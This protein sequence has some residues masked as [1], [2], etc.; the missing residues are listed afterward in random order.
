MKHGMKQPVFFLNILLITV[1]IISINGCS[2]FTTSGPQRFPQLQSQRLPV[3]TMDITIPHLSNCTHED[4]RRLRLN[5]DEPVTML[6]HGCNG[7]AGKFLA[8]ANVFAF[9]GQQT[10]CFNYNDRDSMMDS[11]ALLIDALKTLISRMNN[12]S[13]TVI[14]HSQGGLV[15]RKAFIQERNEKPDWHMAARFRL[16][17]IS[18]PFAGISASEHCGSKT[19]TNVSLGTI[20]PICHMISGDKWFEI[21]SASDFIRNPGTLIQKVDDYTKIVTDERDSCR[22]RNVSGQCVEDDYVFSVAEQYF[23]TIDSDP[24]VDNAEVKAGHME[25]VGDENSPPI[26]LLS[27]LQDRGILA[28]TPPEYRAQFTAVLQQLY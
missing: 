14:G 11:S 12:K 18:S 8:L 10:V 4:D 7:S 26:I 3:P 17:T 16:V 27:I 1:W 22:R 5:E 6:V 24:L 23:L 15:A 25:I 21:T 2:R 28:T 13:V 20:I 19:L 9:H